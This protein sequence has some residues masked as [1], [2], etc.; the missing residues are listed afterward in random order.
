MGKLGGLILAGAWLA[1][2]SAPLSA[3]DFEAEAEAESEAEQD[4]RSGSGGSSGSNWQFDFGIGGGFDPDYDGSDD[5]LASPLPYIALS[6]REIVFFSPEG[7]GVNFLN[8]EWI[9][10]S[11]FV[12]Y[13]F[14]REA[15]D[16][17]VGGGLGGTDN[18]ALFGLN[19]VDGTVMA[20]LAV[21][22]FVGFAEA[23]LSYSQGLGGHKG[24]LINLGL[25]WPIPL[26]SD[27]TLGLI[28]GISTTWAS[29][30]FM[31]AYFGITAD[32]AMAHN[33]HTR[34]CTPAMGVERNP[35]NCNAMT[36]A[37]DLLYPYEG[38]EAK[39][40]IQDYGIDLEL[41]WQFRE[42]WN[43][44]IAASYSRMAGDAAKSPL[45]KIAGSENQIFGGVTI[46][47]SFNW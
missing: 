11:L 22:A 27:E 14:G 43:L 26:R 17:S 34:V 13:D 45:V 47:R 1:L 40:G 16:D 39:S 5:Y 36:V 24:S 37:S 15:D 19:K 8:K 21:D 38:Y 29:D 6:Y 18:E 20:G 25:A 2:L 41:R 3:Q 28:V 23:S 32:E 30:D 31:E 46:S 44:G 7:L 33:T 9:S 12:G 4:R 35:A 10:A 42:K